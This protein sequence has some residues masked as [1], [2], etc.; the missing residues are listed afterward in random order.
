MYLALDLGGLVPFH[1]RLQ[2]TDG[3]C[4]E[5]GRLFVLVELAG[6]LDFCPCTIFGL[7]G[8]LDT[9]LDF[10]RFLKRSRRSTSLLKRVALLGEQ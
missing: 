7:L 1:G 10:E 2:D 5:L 8:G 9:A 3:F 4:G 6:W